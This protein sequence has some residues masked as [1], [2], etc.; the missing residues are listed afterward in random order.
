[1]V[2]MRPELLRTTT[3]QIPSPCP[4]HHPQDPL[5]LLRAKDSGSA[6][7]RQPI[8]KKLPY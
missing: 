1:M 2:K 4:A 8:F 3:A 6:G 5:F 7:F